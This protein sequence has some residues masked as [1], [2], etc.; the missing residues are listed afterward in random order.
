MKTSSGGSRRR[1]L[2]G[3]VAVLIILIGLLQLSLWFQSAR[4]TRE[5]TLTLGE[6]ESQLKELDND[7]VRLFAPAELHNA[8]EDL[9][10]TRGVVKENRPDYALQ[11]L[12]RLRDDIAAV[13][14]RTQQCRDSVAQQRPSALNTKH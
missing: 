12:R 7:T 5:A 4:K 11:W 14:L 13:K 6:L 2:L 8:Q 1:I 3:A 9:W 10:M